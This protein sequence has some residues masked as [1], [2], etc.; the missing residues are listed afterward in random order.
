MKA[1]RKITIEFDRVKI[2][3]THPRKHQAWCEFCRADAEFV[4]EVE[5]AEI[6]KLMHTQ[7][8][9]VR[10]ENIHMYQPAGGQMLVC[11]NSMISVNDP[12]IC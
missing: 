7:G 3:T 11:L 9:S 8:L 12:R 1:K 10:K 5:A 4:D 2:T 6:A